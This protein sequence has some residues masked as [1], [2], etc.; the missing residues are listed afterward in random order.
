M[1]LTQEMN[2]FLVPEILEDLKHVEKELFEHLHSD[3]PLLGEIAHYLIA[4]GGK[5]VRP[6]LVLLGFRAAGGDDI[7]GI[8]P[9][10]AAIELIHTA[11]LIHDDINDGSQLR[12]GRETANRKFGNTN[13]LVAG[14][15]LFVKAFRI[16]GM[17]DWE[18]VK[19]IADACSQLAEG[20]VKQDGNRYNTDLTL[21]EYLV[22]IQKKT[23]SLIKSCVKV[24]AF[25]SGADQPIVDALATYA[26][27]VGM[28]F[29]ITDDILDVKGSSLSI[30]KPR[31]NDIMEGQLSI[32]AI[33]A[34]EMLDDEAAA[35]L[36][37]IIKLECKTEQQLFRAIDLVLST[38]ALEES[39]TLAQEYSDKATQELM[40]L[41][42]TDFRDNLEL[43]N[44]M[45]I[46]RY[47]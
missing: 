12:R 26:D 11:S 40:K 36:R 44:E 2:E 41:P 24:G 30:G 15:F 19:M 47:Y 29:Q 38:N 46:Q 1:N 37:D 4:A 43:L 3:P 35:E 32:V 18:V 23:A 13:A 20:E 10:A 7:D 8:V 17:Y 45:M 42:E 27:N 14:D 31:G 22:T 6:A 33:K 21:D 25:L 39:H 9:I 16:G 5:R 28:A 34:L